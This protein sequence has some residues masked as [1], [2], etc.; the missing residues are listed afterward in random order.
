MD[1]KTKSLAVPGPPP[2]FSISPTKRIN[3]NLHLNLKLDLGKI[4]KKGPK[5]PPPPARAETI[6]EEEDKDEE[7]KDT[8][9]SEQ[10]SKEI[11]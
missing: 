8:S 10:S 3:Q 7:L 9:T 5:K 11:K 2:R 6:K 1:N 4:G